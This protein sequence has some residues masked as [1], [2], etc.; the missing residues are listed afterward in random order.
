MSGPGLSVPSPIERFRRGIALAALVGLAACGLAWGTMPQQFMRSYLLGF[1]FWLGLGLGSLAVALLHRLTG[2]AWGELIRRVLEAA[3]RTLPLMAVLFLPLAFNL[4]QLYVWAQPEVVAHDKVLLHK[5]AYLNAPFFW[6]RAAVF[7]MVW[8]A[9]ATYLNRWSRQL[10]ERP[11]EATARA[12]RR[13]AGGGLVALV[14]TITLASIDWA[15]SLSAHWYSTMYGVLF[16]V[17]QTLAAL[18]LS[19]VVVALLARGA[20]PQAL[21]VRAL[22]DVGKL[23]LAFVMLWA[24]VNFSQFLVIWAGNIPE[25]AVWYVRRLDGGWQIIALA[26][27]VFHFVLPFLLL[28]SYDLKRNARLLGGLAAGVLVARFV[29]LFW[30]V[31][32]DLAGHGHRG[33]TVHP[34]DIIVPLAMGAVWLTYFAWHLDRRPPL[35]LTPTARV[36]GG[37]Q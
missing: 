15:M 27:V 37:A 1:L 20:A 18:A 22:H 25:E 19:I 34:L 12:L 6:A 26:L 31:G 36:A 16:L 13:L 30:L 21:P 3:T 4:K 7:F 29:D 32:P 11:D 10:E 33:L 35:G 28:L 17:G 24:Y 8:I 5:A 23:L 14:L 2:G 9:L